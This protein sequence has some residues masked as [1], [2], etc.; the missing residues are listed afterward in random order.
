MAK[1][2]LVKA[3]KPDGRAPR[4]IAT[5]AGRLY[6]KIKGERCHED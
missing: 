3:E 4:Y 5:N 1:Y 2:G 6:L